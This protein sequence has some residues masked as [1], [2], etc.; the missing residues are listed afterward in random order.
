MLPEDDL[1]ENQEMNA[2]QGRRLNFYD[3]IAQQREM[4]EK[5]KALDQRNKLLFPSPEL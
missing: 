2:A 4:A 5:R 1:L 3:A